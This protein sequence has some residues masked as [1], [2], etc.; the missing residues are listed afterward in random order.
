MFELLQP[1]FTHT[2]TNF[3]SPIDPYAS[4]I[5]DS[6]PLRDLHPN[7]PTSHIDFY[8]KPHPITP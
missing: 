4:Y 1:G 5:K 6:Y 8:T 7:I 2:S 3:Y